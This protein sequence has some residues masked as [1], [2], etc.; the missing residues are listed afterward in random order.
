[1]S[2]ILQK[3]IQDVY[4]KYPHPSCD[5]R[6]RIHASVALVM[7]HWQIA[8]DAKVKLDLGEINVKAINK[9]CANISF[10]FTTWPELL[11]APDLSKLASEQPL[12]HQ[13]WLADRVSDED[14]DSE[15]FTFH[16]YHISN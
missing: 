12:E 5:G 11:Y 3:C 8:K 9:A 6:H 7:Q 1:M 15:S 2:N 13:W 16:M 14:E 10:N 4:A